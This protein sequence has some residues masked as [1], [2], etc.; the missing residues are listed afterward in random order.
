MHAQLGQILDK[1]YRD[2]KQ[3]NKNPLTLLKSLWSKSRAIAGY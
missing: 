1:K 2:Q 3:T